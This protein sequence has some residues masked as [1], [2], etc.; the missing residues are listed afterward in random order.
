MNAIIFKTYKH[1]GSRFEGEFIL[2]IPYTPCTYVLFNNTIIFDAMRPYLS[3]FNYWLIIN[4]SS[5]GRVY[6]TEKWLFEGDYN[7]EEDYNGEL[8]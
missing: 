1:L 8:S 5:S 4:L 6:L 7:D 3:L 2:Y